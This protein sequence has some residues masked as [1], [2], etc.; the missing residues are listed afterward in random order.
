VIDVEALIEGDHPARLDAQGAGRGPSKGVHDIKVM[1]I[2]LLRG[3]DP[4]V[5]SRPPG[6]LFSDENS[7]VLTDL[8][9]YERMGD[10]GVACGRG[11][12]PHQRAGDVSTE[13]AQICSIGVHFDNSAAFMSRTP[14][15]VT[16]WHR[17][18]IR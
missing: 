12:P 9:R 2:R 4:L 17:V 10:R 7:S 15:K 13:Y 6:R 16:R 18:A 1:R 3:A 11:R 8:L 14:S 5:R